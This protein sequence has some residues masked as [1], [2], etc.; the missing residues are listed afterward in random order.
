MSDTLQIAAG[1]LLIGICFTMMITMTPSMLHAMDT[2]PGSPW[3]NSS[4]EQKSI[5]QFQTGIIAL[6][7]FLL[8]IFGI[9][10]IAKGRS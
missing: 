5:V 10:L 2:G 7:P 4:A 3:E 9:V 8:F 1:I 6:A